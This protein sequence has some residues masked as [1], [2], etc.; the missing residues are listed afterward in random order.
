MRIVVVSCRLT[1]RRRGALTRLVAPEG[2]SAFG[3]LSDLD[4]IGDTDRPDAVVLDG[5]IAA[6]PVALADRLGRWVTDGTALLALGPAAGAASDGWVDLLGTRAQPP[7]A[8]GEVYVRVVDGDNP[9]VARL[10]D[11]FPV[12]DVFQP[13]SAVTDAMRPVLQVTYGFVQQSAVLAGK[14]GR[15]RV[16]ASGLGGTDRALESPGLAAVLRRALRPRDRLLTSRPLGVGIVGY[17]PHGGMGFVHGTAAAATAGLEAVAIGDSDPARRKAAEHD[18]P[19]IRVHGT[20]DELAGDDAVDL[21]VVAT[22]PLAHV[23]VVSTLLRAGKHVVCEKPL[24]FTVADADRLFALAADNGRVL[25][26]N[27]SRRWDRDFRAVQRVID[28]GLLGEVFNV[29]TFVGG[30]DHPCR[31]WHSDATVSGGMVYDWGA[32]HID[33][34]VQLLGAVPSRVAATGHKRVW[35]DVTNLDQLRVRMHWDDGREAEFLASDVAAVRRPKF[36]VQ[37][38]TATLVGHYRDVVFEHL[39]PARGYVRT[40]AHHAEAPAALTLATYGSGTG[41][42]EAAVALG[43]ETPF[44][45]HRNL[46]DHLLLGEPLAVLPDSIRQVTAVLE[47]ATHSAAEGGRPVDLR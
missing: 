17:G 3:S 11:E 42:T 19:G 41:V 25:T 7:T 46:A 40:E 43:P 26:V 45:F 37:G 21:A 9:L 23:G 33:W 28:D 39:D 5:P 2:E 22:P 6:P 16:V 38:T 4:A 24:C 1:D 20:V 12:V 36:Y 15:G 18:F 47:A 34:I 8:G 27:Q 29:E 32:H 31:A 10:D 44:A 35:H 30:F 13:L 14:R